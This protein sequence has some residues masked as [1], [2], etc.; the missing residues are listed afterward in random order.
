[1][2]ERPLSPHLTI[3]RM[4]RYT[5]LSS[6]ANR[7]AGLAASAGLLVLA[8]WLTAAARGPDAYARARDL[9]G[10][11]IARVLYALVLVAFLYHAVAGIRHLIWDTGRGL[12]RAQSQ[13][14][15]WAIA[16]VTVILASVLGWAFF[17]RGGI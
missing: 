12:E 1:M 10:S 5:L 7:L 17:L 16:V 6:F 4:S 2:P 3:Y 8:Y 15:A 11:P 13:R 14:S 9:L